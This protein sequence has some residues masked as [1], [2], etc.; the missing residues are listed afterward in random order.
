MKKLLLCC[1]I[2]AF[3]FTSEINAQRKK[4]KKDKNDQT[5]AKPEKS[6]GHRHGALHRASPRRGVARGHTMPV[7]ARRV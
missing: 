5:T 3:T 4:S 1:L 2:L 6:K 7:R